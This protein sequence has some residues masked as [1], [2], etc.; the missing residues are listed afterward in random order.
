MKRKTQQTDP[1]SYWK[2]MVDAITTLMMVILLVLM[3]FMLNFLT[4]NTENKEDDY[5]GYENGGYSYNDAFGLGTPTPTPTLSVTPTPTPTP[6]IEYDDNNDGGGGEENPEITPNPDID[7]NPNEGEAGGDKSAIYVVL[8]DEETGKAIESAGVLFELYKGDGSKQILSTH[9]PEL[10]TYTAF[11]TTEDGSFYLPEKI[12]FG[13]YY[14]R[15]VTELEGYDYTGDVAFEV[16]EPHEWDD[17]L[18]VKVPFGPSRNRL[19]IQYNDKSTGLPIADV[20]FNVIANGNVL[21]EDGTVRFYSGE[22]VDV[23]TCDS[24]GYGVSSELYLGDYIVEP[25]GTPFGYAA[26][27]KSSREIT[28]PRRTEPGGMAPLTILYSDKTTVRVNIHDELNQDIPIGGLTYTLT[29][30]GSLNDMRTIVTDEMGCFEIDGLNKNTSYT[31][32]AS[33]SVDGYI[34]D[35]VSHEFTVDGLGYI[36]GS[37]MYEINILNRLIRVEID[38]VD[39]VARQPIS[40]QNVSIIDSSGNVIESWTSDGS[41]HS[42]AGIEPGIY[43]V[44]VNDERIDMTI[45]VENTE[46][47]Q[48]FSTTI[49]TQRSYNIL[50]VILAIIVVVLLVLVLII[51]RKS[52]KRRRKKVNG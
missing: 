14:L 26:P 36:N 29:S 40:G 18:V 45:R 41:S 51:T 16:N 9:Y 35:S 10:I 50:Y 31:L 7:I 20:A 24:S 21:T 22:V 12:S 33:G 46:T 17:V 49:M 43:N 6:I 27:D 28:L 48:K 23:I 38:V 47:I 8:V 39:R 1:V 32:K 3:F 25:V 15:Q 11:E 13:S 19:Q 2:S 42:I 34:M 52:K 30:V 44:L 37:P 5:S 4:N